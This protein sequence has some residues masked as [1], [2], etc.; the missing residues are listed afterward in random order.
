M[1]G[2]FINAKEET[3]TE[4]ELK[5]GASARVDQMNEIIGSRCFTAV[6]MRNGD[7][8]YVDDEGL[9]DINADSKFIAIQDYPQPLA[10]NGIIIGPEVEGDQ[11][12][13]GYTMQNAQTKKDFPIMFLN[14]HQVMGI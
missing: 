10:G 12:P 4:I 5:E 6:R 2:L 11:Y 3:V 9:L 7:F 8:L 14:V 13:D 1:K